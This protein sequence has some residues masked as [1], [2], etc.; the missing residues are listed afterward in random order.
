MWNCEKCG[1]EFKRVNQSHFCVK[2][3]TVEE[4]ILDLPEEGRNKIEN[5]RKIILKNLSNSEES[6]KWNMPTYKKDNIVVHLAW[7]K[8]HIGLFV[9]EEAIENFKEDL[10]IYETNKG[11][12][13]ILHTKEI[14]YDLIERMII[15]L[16]EKVRK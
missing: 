15:F 9:G 5:I 2:I 3:N 16:N 11:N 8:N 10:L 13:K 7:Y 1:R 12:I 14:P 6:I 4:Y